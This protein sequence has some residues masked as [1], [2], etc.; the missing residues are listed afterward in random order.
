KEA[1]KQGISF[2]DF[3][4]NMRNQLL[5]Q[6]VIGEEVGRRI[7]FLPSEVSKYYEDHKE[8]LK[9]PESVRLAEILVSTDPKPNADGKAPEEPPEQAA[10]RLARP[11]AKAKEWVDS[12]QKGAKFEDTAKKS[13]DGPTADQGGDLGQF[14]RG[15]LAKELEDKVFALP[16][17]GMTESIRPR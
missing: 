10:R 9:Q 3:K 7:Q 8:D 4:D 11:K 12:T 2:E 5:T 13:S 15:Q 16:E 14:K 1:S 17:G 6:R